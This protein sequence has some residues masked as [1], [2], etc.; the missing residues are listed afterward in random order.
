[1]LITDVR[2]I[3]LTGPCTNDP[4]LSEARK[5]RSAAFIEI[6]TNTELIGL[7]ETYIGY[8]FPESVQPIVDFFKPILIGQSVDDIPL[9][10]KRMYHCGNF[11]CRTGLGL[12]VLGGIEAALWDLR[13]KALGLPVY[14]LLGGLQHKELPC[15]ATGGPSNYPPDKLAAKLEHYLS[16][17]FKGVKIGAGSFDSEKGWFMPETDLEIAE[18]EAAKMEHVRSVIGKDHQIMMDGHMGNSPTN[19]WTLQTAKTV[20]KALEPYGLLFFEEPLHYTD[21][22]AYAELRASTSVPIAGGECL[23]GSSEWQLYADLD[24]F[25]IGQPDASFVG[26]LSEFMAVAAMYARKGKGIATHAWGAGGSLMQN[27]HCGFAC[28][29]TSILEIPPNFA[30]LHS[31]IVTDSFAMVNGLVI[32]PEAPG[33]GIVL[34]EATKNKYPFIPG[35]GEFNSVPGKLLVT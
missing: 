1:M 4:F 9:L 10:W 6:H 29:N 24:C 34:T 25:D 22:A 18:F 3:L 5:L 8:F 14:E 33:L 23:T 21:V 12:S 31:E 35:S 15:Y 32:P 20:M 26:G 13:G 2:T 19:T 28:P 11:W 7:G 16:L 30:G 27:I 17:G